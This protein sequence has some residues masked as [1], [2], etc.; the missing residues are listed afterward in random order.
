M[1][2]DNGGGNY[3]GAQ[4][5]PV[6]NDIIDRPDAAAWQDRERYTNKARREINSGSSR[7]GQA[8]ART[9]APHLGSGS[10]WGTSA[11]LP[12]CNDPKLSTGGEYSSAVAKCN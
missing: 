2:S 10:Q 3:S 8:G 1:W 11:V 9:P 6:K 12:M 7:L 5:P 4:E